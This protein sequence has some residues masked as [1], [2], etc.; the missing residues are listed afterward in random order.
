[1]N[2]TA[3]RAKTKVRNPQE[4]TRPDLTKAEGNSGLKVRKVNSRH[5][6]PAW[7]E[8]GEEAGSLEADAES[9]QTGEQDLSSSKGQK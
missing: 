9:K 6:G 5:G 7:S 2:G 4:N 3:P 1:M 8:K